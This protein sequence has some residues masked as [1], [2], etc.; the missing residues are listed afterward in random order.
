MNKT[1]K[2]QILEVIQRLVRVETKI[3]DG[4]KVNEKDH[5]DLKEDI[6]HR[7]TEYKD[8]E[9]RVDDLEMKYEKRLIYWKF[10]AAL[11]SPI[12][13]AVIVAIGLQ[14]FGL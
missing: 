7:K 6:S 13:T 1:E 5:A 12:V 3:E 10:M 9:K 2:S 4:F 11:G 14:F 8:L